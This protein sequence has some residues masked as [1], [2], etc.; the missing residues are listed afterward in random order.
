MMT[1]VSPAYMRAWE[2]RAFARG[3]SALALMESAAGAIRDTLEEALG[4]LPNRR[5]L[6]LCG[7]GKFAVQF[8]GCHFGIVPEDFPLSVNR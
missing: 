7:G 2:Q 4:G 1:A 6:F 3:V 8:A 5:I